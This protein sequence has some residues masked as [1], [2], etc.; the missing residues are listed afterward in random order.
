MHGKHCRSTNAAYICRYVLCAFLWLD[1]LLSDS[2]IRTCVCGILVQEQ[3]FPVHTRDRINYGEET[4]EFLEC[5]M[6][7][8]SRQSK[9]LWIFED[10][11][12][13]SEVFSSAKIEIYFKHLL[14]SK[15]HS[16]FHL[17]TNI[18]EVLR[19]FLQLWSSLTFY[20]IL[21]YLSEI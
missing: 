16:F 18:Q 15:S 12:Y 8:V 9:P 4:W 3:C 20:V 21:I 17:E 5:K 13:V 1:A 19:I 6:Y 7:S 14:S 11:E 10:I 2:Y